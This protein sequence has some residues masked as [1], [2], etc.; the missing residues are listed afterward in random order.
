MEI[1]SNSPESRSLQIT[2]IK[3]ALKNEHRVNVF[4]NDSYEF[5]LDLA[6]VVD[7]KLKVGQTITTEKLNEYKHASEF[8]KLYQR[9]LE[10][11]LSRPH[12]IKETRDY[13]NRK[14]K[15]RETENRQAVRNRK[16]SKEDREKYH[17]QTKELPLFSN[18]D[19]EKIVAQ[20]IERDYLDDEKFAKTYLENRNARKGSSLK[21]LRLELI[22]KGI[23]SQIIDELLT[24]NIRNDEEEIQKI[25]A[26]KRARYD[27]EKL[28]QY[29]LRQGFSYELVRQFVS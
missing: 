23:D 7:F 25:I 20:L 4:V 22:K 28:T 17:L 16:R 13:L 2:A 29:L 14:L 27:D 11:V 19:I 21:K 24:N 1:I 8:G 26:K 18:D 6:Q 12:S 3:P 15:K 5:S 10:W 9:T